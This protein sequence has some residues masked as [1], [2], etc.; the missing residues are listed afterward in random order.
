MRLV[1][2]VRLLQEVSIPRSVEFFDTQFQKQVRASD[3]ALNPF[4]RAIVPYLQGEVLD[5]GCGLG[6]LSLAAAQAGCS[7]TA[8]DASPT[9]I[10]DLSRRAGQLGVALDARV[11]DLRRWTGNRQ[12]DCVVSIGLLMFFAC[13]DARATLASLRDA[14][15]PGGLAAVN[16]LVEGT[17]YMDMF[18]PHD[19]CLLGREELSEA[20]AGWQTLH[21]AHQDFAAPG[22]T[23][24]RFHTLVARR[25]A[26]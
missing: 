19:Y 21:S 15:R 3:Y 6:N 22:N 8:L 14:V 12:Y 4:E 9:G 11:V 24:K 5:L 7:V 16:V 17:T 26:G 13:S 2:S 25:P 23:F 1:Y 18:D 10:A 20:F